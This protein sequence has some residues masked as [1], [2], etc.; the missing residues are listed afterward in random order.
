[1][2]SSGSAP[3]DVAAAAV[4]ALSTGSISATTVSST[5]CSTLPQSS[6]PSSSAPDAESH[7]HS[8]NAVDAGFGLPQ[9]LGGPPISPHCTC[10]VPVSRADLQ[11]VESDEVLLNIFINQLSA[12][13][14]FVVI[15]PGTT[16]QE[17]AATRPFLIQVIRMVSSVRHLRSMWGQSRA[18]IKHIGEAMLIRSERSMDLLQG[19]IVFLGFYHYFCVSHAHF[20]NLTHLAL[21]L[22][23]DMG[24]S[25][26]PRSGSEEGNDGG[27]CRLRIVPRNPRMVV[28]HVSDEAALQRTNEERRA[29]LGVWYINSK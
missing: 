11:P 8:Q 21:S 16:A 25:T 17:M 10:R 13:F 14:P 27:E 15:P 19:I 5:T 28:T 1:M 26:P 23:G 22:I 9:P 24:L 18:V 29:L 7:S 3:S 12:K 6:P 4:A 2:S 20:N